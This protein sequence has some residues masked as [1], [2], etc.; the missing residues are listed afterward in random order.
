MKKILCFIP[1][2]KNSKSIKNKNLIKI[3]NKSLIYYTLAF[4]KKFKNFDIGF[5]NV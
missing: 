2:R 5:G 1:A 3:K 4:A